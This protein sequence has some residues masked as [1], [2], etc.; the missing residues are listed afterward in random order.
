M[1]FRVAYC[2]ILRALVL[3]FNKKGWK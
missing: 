1:I 2:G 3:R